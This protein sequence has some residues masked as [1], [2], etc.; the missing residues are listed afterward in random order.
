MAKS[1][2]HTSATA[3]K[4]SSSK[5]GSSKPATHASTTKSK[6][7]V[8][9]ARRPPTQQQPTADRYK[10]I[11]Q[12]LADRGYFHGTADGAWGAEST[13]ALRRFQRE[14]NLDADGKIG[15]L[16]LMALGLGP[17]RGAPAQAAR[18]PEETGGAAVIDPPPVAQPQP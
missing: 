7:P 17:Q 6:K 11:Q 10:E 1:T 8:V 13:D 5:T 14:Q 2:P 9:V 12:A 15:A 4:S 16:S 18:V 3:S